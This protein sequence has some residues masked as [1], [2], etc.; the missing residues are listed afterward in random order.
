MKIQL[1][2]DPFTAVLL[3]QVIWAVFLCRVCTSWY[4]EG[5]CCLYNMWNCTPSYTPS[6]PGWPESSRLSYFGIKFSLCVQYCSY[7][8]V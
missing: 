4:F 3:C 2:F 8:F 7:D 5:A 1:R 6:H